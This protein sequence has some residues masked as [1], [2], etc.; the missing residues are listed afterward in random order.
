MRRLRYVAAV[1]L[2]ATGGGAAT[3]RAGAGWYASLRK[4]RWTPPSRAFGP[5]WTVLYAQ[6]AYSA[7]RVDRSHDPRRARALSLW[8]LQMGLNAAWTPVFFAARRP[9]AAAL[10]ITALLPSAAAT[11]VETARID[12]PAGLIYAPYLAWATFA[13]ALNLEIWR[14]NRAPPT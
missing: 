4:P 13:T 11:A 7:W 10:V 9:G 6:I 12:R 5:V 3:V 14:L 2:A 1:A 8:W